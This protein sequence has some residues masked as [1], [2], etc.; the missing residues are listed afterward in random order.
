MI[1]TLSPH[2]ITIPRVN[3]TTNRTC[4]SYKFDLFIWSGDKSAFPT[5][6]EYTITRV[7]AGNSAT[8]DKVDISRIVNSFFD[9]NCIQSTATSLE[10][11]N[12]QYWVMIK[13]YYDDQPITAQLRNVLL[14]MKGYGYFME[15]QNPQIPSNKILLE[16]DEFKVSRNGYFVLPIMMD[17]P[18]DYDTLDYNN[19]DYYTN[20]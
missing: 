11:G 3:P 5:I 6:P 16:G 15:G 14:A 19:L 1:K 17:T 8:D 13:V 12:N 20:N 9:V 4:D 2:Y 7:N 18:P 10:N